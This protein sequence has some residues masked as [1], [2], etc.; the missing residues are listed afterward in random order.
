MNRLR[1]LLWAVWVLV[2]VI[3]VLLALL[4]GIVLASWLL[5]RDLPPGQNWL[6]DT[7]LPIV[8][9]Q[10]AVQNTAIAGGTLRVKFVVNRRRNCPAV[11]T[12]VNQDARGERHVEI[13][14]VPSPLG[15][16]GRDE[17]ISVTRV[18]DSFSPGRA[19]LRI[20]RDYYCNPLQRV[21]LM[22]PATERIPDIEYTIVDLS[23]D[24][25]HN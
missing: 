25:S 15:P 3:I 10:F 8:T 7:D 13:R 9:E 5:G 22:R 24:W 4:V 21:G 19:R 2:A 20:I 11:A 16:L 14:R 17:F 12:R 23:A 6:T 1:H 18:P